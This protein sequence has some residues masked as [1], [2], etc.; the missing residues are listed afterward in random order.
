MIRTSGNAINKVDRK[1]PRYKALLAIHERLAKKDPTIWGPDAQ[2]EAAIRLNWIDLPESS[3]DLLPALDALY[4]KHRDKKTIILCGMGGS[5]LGPEV[6]AASFKKSIFILDSTD[7]NYVKHALDCD[8]SSALVIVSSKSGSTIE[9]ASQRSLF[10]SQFTQARLL[11]QNHMVIVTDPGSPLDMQSRAEGF[12]VI[13]ADPN[14]GGR[15]SVLSAFGLVPAA[16]I[17]VDVSILLDNASDTKAAFL[18]DATTVVD[19]AYLLA[20]CAGQYLSFT[21]EGSGM[22]GMSDW[23]EQLVAESTGKNQVGR[24]PV[25]IETHGFSKDVFS[26]AYTGNADLVVEADLAS[27]FIIWEW[28]TALVGAALNIDPFNQPNVTEAKEQTSALL[29]QWAG[30]LPSFIADKTDAAVEIFG[31]GTGL[32][33]ALQSFVNTVPPG[34]YVAIMA[35]LDRKDDAK[36]ARI[37]ALLSEKIGKPVT[38][39]WGPRFLHSTGQFHKGGQ[40]N[41]AFLQIT[42]TPSHDI[43]IPGQI[44]GFKTL[45]SAQALGDGNALASRKYPLLRLNLTNRSAGIDQLLEAIQIL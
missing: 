43:D 4:A 38:F 33:N 21:D 23:V 5:S 1:D 16:L 37:Q 6:I 18:N 24:L 10:Q 25:V 44:F 42:G 9:T 8:L 3:R 27:Q 30:V 34:G 31:T 45:F 13:N 28:V 11:P 12:S 41:G 17:G 35:Y 7:P 20:Y 32:V 36:I 39:G 29:K 14:V 15:F 22:P 26:I 2:A 40:Q 19:I